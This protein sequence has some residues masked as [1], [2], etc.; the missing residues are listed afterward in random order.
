M[1]PKW[2]V[3]EKIQPQFRSLLTWTTDRVGMS[4]ASKQISAMWSGSGPLSVGPSLTCLPSG[5]QKKGHQEQEQDHLSRKAGQIL[6]SCCFL[7][8]F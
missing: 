5:E 1:G 3:F 8:I 2:V 7:P 6:N 4:V